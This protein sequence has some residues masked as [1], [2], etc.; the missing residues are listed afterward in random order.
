MLKS[1]SYRK[2]FNNQASTFCPGFPSLEVMTILK[3]FIVQRQKF[4]NIQQCE[5]VI[6]SKI[7]KQI[8]YS[9]PGMA[10]SNIITTQKIKT[11]AKWGRTVTKTIKIQYSRHQPFIST[12]RYPEILMRLSIL[13]STAKGLSVTASSTYCLLIL[14]RKLSSVISSD[15]GL[16]SIL[17]LVSRSLRLNMHRTIQW[18]LFQGLLP[19]I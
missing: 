4:H 6:V 7:K 2:I 5:C 18:D 13:R 9:Q 3:M 12:S 17:G 19:G 15:S 1:L 8:I 14:Y 16:S 10:Q 11:G